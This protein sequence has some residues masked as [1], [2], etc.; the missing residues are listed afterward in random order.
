MLVNPQRQNRYVYALNN[1]YKYADSD[2]NSPVVGAL[3]FSAVSY[4]LK[5]DNANAPTN[6][7]D[8]TYKS[9]GGRTLAIGAVG[10][11]GV[12]GATALLTPPEKGGTVIGHL[13]EYEKVAEKMGAN[14]LKPSRAHWNPQKQYQFI[15][16][17]IKRGDDVYIGTD[18]RT[19]SSV[20][21][22][23]IKQL[24]KA[25]YKPK[26]LGSKWLTKE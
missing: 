7:A 24:T 3:I 6:S 22:R 1:P 19:G 17:V 15:N 21:K 20:L 25:G 8:P 26:E 10:G 5:P 14:Y 18:I 12:R 16:D 9:Y 2:G 4:L 11:A 13:P 23:E